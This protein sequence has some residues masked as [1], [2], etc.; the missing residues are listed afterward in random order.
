MHIPRAGALAALAATMTVV[1]GVAAHASTT[2]TARTTPPRGGV[3]ELYTSGTLATPVRAYVIT[4]AFA[5]SG[6]TSPKDNP[7]NGLPF[8]KG[9]IR[10]NNSA[11]NAAESRIYAHLSRYVNASTCA[12]TYH[13][14]APIKLVSG[15]G[16]YAGITG[17]V[18]LHNTDVGVLPRTS[19]GT[20]NESP[21][22]TPIGFL[23]ES[24]GS[25][26]VSFK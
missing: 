21:N 5:D 12:L 26:R 14:T 24:Y 23:S 16:T 9:S 8:T 1:C 10:I 20:C 18:T 7:A 15:T 19:A 2:P 17:T 6:A 25:G 22:V 3:I 11:A 13:Y 4:G